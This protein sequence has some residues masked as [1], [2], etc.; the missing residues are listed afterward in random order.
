[1]KYIKEYIKETC[2]L[3]P[4]GEVTLQQSE[5]S[6]GWSGVNVCVNNI[7]TPLFI[8]HADYAEW[9]ESKLDAL[10]AKNEQKSEE[11]SEEKPEQ[12]SEKK[13]EKEPENSIEQRFKVGDWVIAKDDGGTAWLIAAIGSNYQ[14]Y[15]M[16]SLRG[17]IECADHSYVDNH[18]RLWNIED[19][20]DGD[21]LAIGNE[22]F[23]FKKKKDNAPTVYISHCFCDSA[24]AF[25]VTKGMSYGEFL[26][27]EN[28]IKVCP[29]T[30][31]QRE[32]LFKKI[33]EAG[34]E[35]DANQKKLK[36]QDEPK[37]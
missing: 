9:L 34:Y 17:T 30:N 33:K 27:M 13:P 11:K 21:V 2:F 1:M 25:R 37:D 29:A 15:S 16:V 10:K 14:D 5:D 23:L 18:Y 31:E 24:G 7:E 8:A 32:F 6:A 3:Q 36:K 12:K 26:A 22:Y 19:A 28:G 35:W 4:L 20:R